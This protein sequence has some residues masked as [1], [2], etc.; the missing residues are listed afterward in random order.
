MAVRMRFAD[1]GAVR[2]VTG[3]GKRMLEILAAPYG[4][5]IRTDRL[6]Q[7]LSARTDFMLEVG[8]RR[9]TLYL[10]GFSPQKRM[11]GKPTKLGV[12]EVIRRDELGLWVRT[13]LDDSE[14][15]TRTWDAA[16]KGTARASTG[17]VNYLVRPQDRSDGSPTP[18]EVFVWPI[19]E[20]SVFDA[21][22]GRMPVSDDAVVLPLRA[23]FNECEIELP[24]SFE[25]GEDKNEDKEDLA[26]RAITSEEGDSTMTPEEIQALIDAGVAAGLKAA[27]ATKES[28][29]EAEKAMRAKIEAEMKVDPAYRSTFNIN[30][31]EGD[32]GLSP[33]ELETFYFMR[34]LIEDGKTAAEGGVP[35]SQAA[36]R[37][38]LEESEAAEIGP[39]VP[40]DLHNQIKALRGKYSIVRRAGMTIM[41]TDKLTYSIPTEVTA[42]AVAPTILE[43]GA[44]TDLQN[45][46]GA[47]TAT[48]LKKGGYLPVTEEGLE[49]QTLFQQWLVK[50][51]ARSMALAENATLNVL[52]TAIDGVEVAATHT[53]TDAELLAGYFALAQEYRDEA[54]WIMNDGT[55]A[56]IRAM[57]IANPRAYGEIGFPY[58]QMGEA[59]EHLMGKPVFTNANWH[60]I[61]VAADDI[62]IIDLVNL[63]ECI[64]WVER[65]GISIF[66]D[67]YSA[68][69]STGVINYLFSARFN[70]TTT[71]T[72]ALSGIDDHT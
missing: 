52:T 17:S 30:K 2:A 13:E 60:S 54:V 14:L 64:T 56:Y 46:F 50:G 68:R 11:M 53:L 32:K 35:R 27:E 49:D 8:D 18:G 48:M 55:L 69:V 5:P 42:V 26:A 10:H 28:A 70:G 9:P 20:I 71:N 3:D 4:S 6:G 72:A 33:E 1:A 22:G 15:S 7:W 19:A 39:M 24:E 61:A 38:A 65:K 40:E 31:I 66:V 62:K 36:A 23:L 44:Y 67:P 34:A 25:A 41:Q 12:A 58:L 57:V 51:V 63:D 21:G 43:E 47:K 16:L 45:T 59:G 29:V 37:A